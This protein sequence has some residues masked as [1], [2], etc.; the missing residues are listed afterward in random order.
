MT[1]HAKDEADMQSIRDVVKDNFL[2][3]HLDAATLDKVALAMFKVRS[4]E[5]GMWPTVW[6]WG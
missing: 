6:Q 3:A 4:R 1:E 5:G 2:F